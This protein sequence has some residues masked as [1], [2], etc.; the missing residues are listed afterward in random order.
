MALLC[1][2]VFNAHN[3]WWIVMPDVMLYLQRTSWALRQ[4]QP[5][6]DIAVY[7]PEDDAYAPSRPAKFRFPN[8]CRIGSLRR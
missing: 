7:L 8:C 1:G 6:N 2:G 4:G 5:D 3:P